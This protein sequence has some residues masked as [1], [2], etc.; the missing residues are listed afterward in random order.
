[1]P[2]TT[3]CRSV[4]FS[5]DKWLTPPFLTTDEPSLEPPRR[6]APQFTSIFVIH[7]H[8]FHRADTDRC[9]SSNSVAP[10]FEVHVPV[11]GARM[12]RHHKFTA[13]QSRQVCSFVQIAPV[14]CHTEFG[15]MVRTTMLPGND[16][17]DMERQERLI[18]LMKAAVFTPVP[19][20]LSDKSAS[21]SINSHRD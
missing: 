14:A 20:T 7:V 4:D 1:M 17:F 21:G 18:V 5:T 15:L 3:H 12:K 10:D 6:F 13:N 8:K 2:C 19:G 11:M 16:V 9:Q